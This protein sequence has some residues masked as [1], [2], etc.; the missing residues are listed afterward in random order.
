M[1]LVIELVPSTCWYTNV[2]SN[3]TKARWDQ[4]RKQCYKDA[5][6][7][8]E[9]CSA[10][11]LTQGSKHPVEC[12]EVW[13]YDDRNKI[14][15]LLRLISLCPRCHQ[16]KHAGLSL[17]KGLGEEIINHLIEVNRISIAK[18]EAHI[19]QAFA[20]WKERSK[21]KWTLDISILELTQLQQT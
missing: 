1:K 4:L 17:L 21:H 19:L 10:T 5:N 8:C 12:H 15:K 7:K 6:Y 18:A 9:I 3:V 16:V 13:Q 11:G 2:R 20:T 14:Q